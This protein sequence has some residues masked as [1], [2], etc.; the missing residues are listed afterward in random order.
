MRAT[1]NC[2]VL[3]PSSD[4]GSSRS[5]PGSPRVATP[6]WKPTRRWRA[7]GANSSGTTSSE[8]PLE[9]AGFVATKIWRIWSHGP[10]DVMREPGWEVFHWALIAFA[11]LGLAL[12]A[13]Q[14]RWEAL[15]LATI[16]LAITALSALLVASPRRVLVMIPLLAPLA[17]ASLIYLA[18]HI[19]HR[20]RYS[21]EKAG[22]G[23]CGAPG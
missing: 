1:R 2:S 15:V 8:E 5:S 11:L 14:R 6:I 22:N 16:F 23:G 9:F 12:L 18:G 3:T 19:Q 17:G 7:W 10:R 21:E 13:W 20:P 4:C